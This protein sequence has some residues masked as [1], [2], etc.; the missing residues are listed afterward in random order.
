[1]AHDNRGRLTV[2]PHGNWRLHTATLPD[3]VLILGTVTHPDGE[4]GALIRFAKTGRYASVTDGVVR[5]VDGR[6]VA[7]ALGQTGR[8]AEIEGG[9]RMAVYLDPISIEIATRLGG[10]SVSHG[11]RL[12]LAKA[13]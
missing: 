12:A 2:D 11:I 6:K 5:P 4:A 13:K 7:A 8:P 3:G 9:R 10:G 1:M